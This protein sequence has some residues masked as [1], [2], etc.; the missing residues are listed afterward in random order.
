MSWNAR[1]RGTS[2]SA[3]EPNAM[4]SATVR[5]LT[6]SVSSYFLNYLETD[7]KKQQTPGRR[8]QREGGLH[9][10]LSLSR[11][12]PLNAAF[13]AALSQPAPDLEPRSEEFPKR[14]ML[15]SDSRSSDARSP[16]RHRACLG[17]LL[18]L[19]SLGPH[20]LW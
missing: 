7:F 19:F 6:K 18:R 17:S 12:A 10:G 3:I 2:F 13:W 9:V 4:D 14:S 16:Q 11:Y 1:V 15:S 8:L 20:I 5:E